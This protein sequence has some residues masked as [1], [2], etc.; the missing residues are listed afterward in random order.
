MTSEKKVQWEV[1]RQLHLLRDMEN[2][3]HMYQQI[4]MEVHQFTRRSLEMMINELVQIQ[5]EFAGTSHEAVVMQVNHYLKGI[6]ARHCLNMSEAIYHQIIAHLNRE[7]GL[8]NPAQ[9]GQKQP[10]FSE[11]LFK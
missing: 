4:M 3:F 11:P 5:Q 7:E 2:D 6:F 8:R 10:S 1:E 9:C